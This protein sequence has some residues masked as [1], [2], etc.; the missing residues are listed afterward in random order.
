MPV[1]RQKN[2]LA[3]RDQQA[4]QLSTLHAQRE[5]NGFT[6]VELLVVVAIVGI[7]AASTDTFIVRV[8]QAHDAERQ[9]PPKCG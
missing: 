5:S 8:S 4:G 2:K 1:V 6:L 3:R 9:L 7:L